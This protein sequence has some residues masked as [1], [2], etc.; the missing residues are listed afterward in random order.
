MNRGLQVQTTKVI[1]LVIAACGLSLAFPCFGSHHKHTSGLTAES[2]LNLTDSDQT[3]YIQGL[4]EAH[5][6]M[7]EHIDEFGWY[8][9][10]TENKNS[11]QLFAIF[12]IWLIK[13]PQTWDK[14]AVHLYEV[15][16][17]EYCD[18]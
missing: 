9:S 18:S 13:H 14:E 17:K 11:E 12:D 2:Y 3:A 8:K 4:H 5:I 6:K 16:L 1:L 15:A 7:S 10:C